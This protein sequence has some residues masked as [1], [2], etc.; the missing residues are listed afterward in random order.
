M[1]LFFYTY[2]CHEDERELAALE[3]RALF[4][5][6]AG[7]GAF[8]SGLGVDPSRSPFLKERI[9]IAASGAT[10]EELAAQV[11]SLGVEADS[12][13]AICIKTGA[14]LDYEDR[15]A[16]ERLVGG[17][18]RG[19][20]DMRAPKQRFGIARFDGRW[21]FG[22]YRE[23][24]AVWLRHNE[25]AQHYSTALPTRI[26]RAVANIAVPDPRG[27]QAVDPCCG[28]GTVLV[29]ALSMGIDMVGSD[30]NPLAVRGARENLRTFGM[31]ENAVRLAD[32]RTLEGEYD[33][34]VLDLPYNV[35]SRLSDEERGELLRAAHRF[36]RRV[37]VLSTEPVEE[38]LRE[39]GWT[40]DDRAI[41]RK[42]SFRREVLVC[43]R[44]A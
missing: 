43:S 18:V 13:K 5:D 4:G 20:A 15:R 6:A 10:L 28:I 35:A 36:A 44:E 30:V 8:A 7:D 16:A 2:A 27:V 3:R 21:L 22:A 42:S 19:T 31:P 1:S 32:A 33:A 17:R 9:E 39:A 11:Q 24:E 34:A 40:V 25:K 23:N 41:A 29:E 14:G 26:A 38:A 37:V 12:F